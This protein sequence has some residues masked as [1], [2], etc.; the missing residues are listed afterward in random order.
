L[1][2]ILIIFVILISGC[3]SANKQTA[4]Y[5]KGGEGADEKLELLKIKPAIYPQDVLEEGIQGHVRFKYD[6]N[7]RGRVVNIE[8]VDEHPY[9]IFRAAALR[10]LKSSRY[11][12]KVV[13]G[14]PVVVKGYMRNFKFLDQSQN[15][16]SV[17]E[18]KRECLNGDL[19]Q[20]GENDC[21]KLD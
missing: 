16:K 18:A 1:K 9:S 14:K 12:P 6:I 5:Y 8:L 15:V 7:E 10:S 21:L 19:K 20:L 13:D 11:K 2:A 17:E 4:Y 3:S